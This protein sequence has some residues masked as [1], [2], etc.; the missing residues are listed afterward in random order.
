MTKKR[1]RT[2][3]EDLEAAL[4]DIVLAFRQVRIRYMLIGALA[5][6]VWGRPRATLDIDFMILG[7]EIAERLIVRL[8]A[9][10]FDRD[11]EWERL[12]PFLEGVQTRFRS[13]TLILDILL[14]RDKHH[15]D[16]FRRRCKKYHRGMYIWFPS[17]EDLILLKLRAG[18]PTDFDDV[19]GIFERVG[20]ALDLRYLS[21]WARRLGIIEELNYVIDRNTG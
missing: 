11:L 17:A 4:R 19:V 1:R 18:R 3:A 5:L 20:D 13:K 16:A 12:N 2:R 6:P 10:G 15:E 7:A 14:R 8:S 21:G 9:L